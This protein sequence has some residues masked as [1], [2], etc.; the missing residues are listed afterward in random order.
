[1]KTI[2]QTLKA[3]GAV[4]VGYRAFWRQVSEL[5]VTP[6]RTGAP[7]EALARVALPDASLRRLDPTASPTSRDSARPD[8]ARFEH[9]AAPQKD[10]IYG[11]SD[12]QK[13]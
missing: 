10:E 9:S 11:G 5:I 12:R 1:M 3:D 6:Q 2:C 8:P 4:T 7:K 13:R